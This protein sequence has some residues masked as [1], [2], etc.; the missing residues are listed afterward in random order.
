MVTLIAP[1]Q[2]TQEK[3]AALMQLAGSNDTKNSGKDLKS[4]DRPRKVSATGP[5]PALSCYKRHCAA[6]MLLVTYLLARG[7][8][9]P[10]A[11]HKGAA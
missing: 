9:V 8:Q 7:C 2:A 1:L 4:P 11:M 6:T 3:L 10:G 5:L